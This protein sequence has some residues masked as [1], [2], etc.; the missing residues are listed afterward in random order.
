MNLLPLLT[1]SQRRTALLFKLWLGLSRLKLGRGGFG[2]AVFAPSAFA[3][4][5]AHNS[6]LETFTV[7]FAAP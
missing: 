7:V 6:E 2:L 1:G 5:V 4:F 3:L